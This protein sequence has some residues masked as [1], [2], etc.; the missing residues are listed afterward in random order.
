VPSQEWGVK[1][2]YPS[3]VGPKIPTDVKIVVGALV[4]TAILAAT[5]IGILASNALVAVIVAVVSLVAISFFLW[6]SRL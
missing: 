2:A 6:M 4:V 3:Y 1:P 5:I